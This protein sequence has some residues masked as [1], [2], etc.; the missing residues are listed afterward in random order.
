MAPHQLA[1]TVPPCDADANVHAHAYAHAYRDLRSHRRPQNRHAKQSA[2]YYGYRGVHPSWVGRPYFD[3]SSGIQTPESEAA[4]EAEPKSDAAW[5][6]KY[7]NLHARM[8]PLL[9]AKARGTAPTIATWTKRDMWQ[10]REDRI[11]PLDRRHHVG[12][13]FREK[14]S[15]KWNESSVGRRMRQRSRE[16]GFVV[17]DARDLARLRYDDMD[18]VY[19]DPQEWDSSWDD[20]EDVAVEVVEE[21]AYNDRGE[22]APVWI[23]LE[24]ERFFDAWLE[25]GVGHC[26]EE[27]GAEIDVEDG[28]LAD[29]ERDD[30]DFDFIWLESVG[31]A[32][33]V[34]ESGDYCFVH[35]HEGCDD[36]S[37]WA[38][39]DDDY[40]MLH[41][42]MGVG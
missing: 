9:L 1:D 2:K 30:F 35:K 18:T 3:F 17:E 28:S 36:P 24:G 8:D 33:D 31:D 15:R 4:T 5:A 13:R 34:S 27:S 7:P 12:K 32:E 10:D 39:E 11:W 16:W 21:V 22:P 41:L 23:D 14:R 20:L 29:Q 26:W 42:E 38:E 6:T 40:D 19:F 37:D 25:N